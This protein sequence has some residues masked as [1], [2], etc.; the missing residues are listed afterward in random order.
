MTRQAMI[1]DECQQL[2]EEVGDRVRQAQV[3]AKVRRTDHALRCAARGIK[4][5]AIYRA[6]VDLP[7]HDVV[8]VGLYTPDRW[9]S[10]SIEAEL[11]HV[12]DKIEDLLEEELIDQG[13]EGRLAVEHF[14][15]D[16]KLFVFRSPVFVPAGKQVNDLTV[17][18]QV[19]KVLLAYEACF[20]ELGDMKPGDGSD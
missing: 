20:R 19:A 6:T 11:M 5:E 3:F 14:R 16:E 1:C 17:I 13:F 8:W 12:G 18:D 9:L 10:E 4:S 15:D 7:E 2:Y